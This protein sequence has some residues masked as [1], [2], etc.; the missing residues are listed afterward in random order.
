[1]TDAIDILDAAG[2]RR[3]TKAG[4][5]RMYFERELAFEI[6]G[7][8]ISFYKTG[9]ISTAWLPGIDFVSNGA[10][11]RVGKIYYDLEDGTWHI[12]TDRGDI[13]RIL[14]AALDGLLKEE[15]Q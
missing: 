9:N 12:E 2:G 11:S 6:A 15:E 1:M 3:W 4:K 10:A 5:D 13:R 8:G 7:G 14:T